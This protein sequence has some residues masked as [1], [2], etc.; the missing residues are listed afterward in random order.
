MAMT[1]NQNLIVVTGA[2]ASSEAISSVT[3][4]AAATRPFAAV[5]HKAAGRVVPA[6]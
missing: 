1:N 3:C 6:I 2:G 4:G 5:G